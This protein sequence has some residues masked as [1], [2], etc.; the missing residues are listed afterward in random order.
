[1]KKLICLL[2]AA[3]LLVCCALPAFAEASGV[4]RADYTITAYS[5]DATLHEN[6]TVTQTERI[7]VDFAVPSR[8]IYR[9]LPVALWVEKDTA[10]GPQEMAYRA[11]VRDLAVTGE[12]QTA[13]APVETD[14]EDGFYSI[15]IGDED[16][17]LT[18]VQTYELTFT[19]DIGDDRVAAYDELFYS[20]NGG[21]WDAPIED[22]RFS[23][24]FEKP[25]T[26]EQKGALAL[27]SGSYG[28]KGNEAGVSGAW[29]GNTFSGAAGRTLYPGEAVT[30]YARLP[31]GYF[32]GE[33]MA[34]VWV[35]WA[36]A[37]AGALLAAYTLL[38]ALSAR[39]R[40]PVVTPECTPP[41]GV[42]S[43]E[44]GYIIDNSADDRDILSLILWFASKGYLAVEG[45]EEDLRLVRKK[46]LPA[47]SPEYQTVFFDALFPAGRTVCQL[48]SLEPAFYEALQ[49]AKLSL[50]AHFTGERALYRPGS[51]GRALA[52]GAGC[53][54][55]WG[56]AGLSCG[57][58]ITG[59]SVGLGLLSGVLLL[60]F[61]LLLYAAAERWQFSGRGARIGWGTGVGLCAAASAGLAYGAALYALT[62]L[63]AVLGSY[64]LALPGVPCRA[65]HRPAHRVPPGNGR[66]PAGP[67]EIH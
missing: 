54:V 27:Y 61:G 38:R 55:L 60:L 33:R 36:F 32:T 28:G 34:P 45:R 39:R 1:M 3:A 5:V 15:R 13:G 8:G 53:A 7:T 47:G 35:F 63:W 46:G 64:L 6:N 62:P 41:D 14:T 40:A 17:W 16:T 12:G 11:R 31:E 23:F 67:A 10:D 49:K 59:A 19:Y 43:A 52:L 44:V 24:T 9:V 37:G 57:A 25:L 66:P 29:D 21:R 30:L 20:L 42:S 56:A 26:Q 58:F 22:F 18:G 51:A 50:S 4:S 2:A 48:H 65:A